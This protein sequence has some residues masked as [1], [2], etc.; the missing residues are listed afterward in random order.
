MAIANQYYLKDKK[1][2]IFQK[3]SRFDQYHNS[4]TVYS[5]VG[6]GSLWCYANQLSQDQIFQAA[7]YGEQ[8][9]RFFVFNYRSGIKVGDSIRYR[10]K[11]YTI[12]RVDTKA[13]YNT[14]MF[15]YAKDMAKGDIP[16]ESSL[17]L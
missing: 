10:E 14:D 1:A 9:T 12:T 15:I 7:S 6:G 2:E 3:T 5:R 13:D 11:W 16:K 8:E 4:V 17:V